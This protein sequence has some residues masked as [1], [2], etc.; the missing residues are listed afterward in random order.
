[1][2]PAPASFGYDQHFL[3]LNLLQN[4]GKQSRR[5]FLPFSRQKQQTFP[6]RI[7][8]YQNLFKP[9][10]PLAKRQTQVLT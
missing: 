6:S 3:L 10:N 5:P 9:P 7:D 4:T 1:M 8:D 2:L